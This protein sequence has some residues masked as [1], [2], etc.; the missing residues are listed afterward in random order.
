MLFSVLRVFLY[1]NKANTNGK[2]RSS[3]FASEHALES[4][5]CQSN[6]DLLCSAACV[7]VC[8]LAAK[9]LEVG[10]WVNCLQFSLRTRLAMA[11]SAPRRQRRAIDQRQ[12]YA[13]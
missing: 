5:V 9:R 10:T 4:R 7:C 11:G 8:V 12:T 2:F 3:Q 6:L 1:N 13:I